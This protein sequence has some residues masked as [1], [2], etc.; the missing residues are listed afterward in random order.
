M[1]DSM[2]IKEYKDIKIFMEVDKQIY[3][4]THP[5]IIIDYKGIISKISIDLSMIQGRLPIEVKLYVLDWA[6]NNKQ[7]LMDKWKILTNLRNK[8]VA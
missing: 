1:L 8:K 3:N 4:F 6:L 7:D 2:C 5:N